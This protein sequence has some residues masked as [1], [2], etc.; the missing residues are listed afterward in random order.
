MKKLFLCWILVHNAL[1]FGIE[2]LSPGSYEG[3]SA[4]GDIQIF[5]KVAPGRAGSFFAV[6]VRGQDSFIYVV[7]SVDSSTYAMTPLEVTH[8]GHIGIV[9]DDP[10]LVVQAFPGKKDSTLFRIT[11]ANSTNKIGYEGNIEFSS[12][13]K[14]EE[15]WAKLD[16]GV[17]STSKSK[18]KK[19]TTTNN[20]SGNMQISEIDLAENEATVSF[21][22]STLNGTFRLREKFPGMYALN[23]QSMLATGQNL[24]SFPTAIGIFI[25]EKRQF[26][27]EMVFLLINPHSGKSSKFTKQ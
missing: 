16:A 21:S 15:E 14:K 5:L 4:K 19:S 9:N 17:F 26:K 10:S 1:S 20:L 12:N 27:T 2:S 13:D 18:T 24:S 25:E 8:D 11:S 23:A 3:K 7:D 6:L 22:T